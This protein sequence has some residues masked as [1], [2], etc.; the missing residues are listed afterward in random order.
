[1]AQKIDTDVVIAKYIFCTNPDV[2]PNEAEFTLGNADI[3]KEK[4]EE[5]R[6]SYMQ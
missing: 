3:V 4:Y 6:K 5:Y 2:H 1:M